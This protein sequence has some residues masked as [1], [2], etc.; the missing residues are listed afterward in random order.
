MRGTQLRAKYERNRYILPPFLSILHRV[1]AKN[2]RRGAGFIR[3]SSRVDRKAKKPKSSSLYTSHSA[4]L[5]KESLFA[6]K[7]LDWL[8]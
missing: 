8:K 4:L 2:I 1:I 5:I 7:T 6:L 3:P